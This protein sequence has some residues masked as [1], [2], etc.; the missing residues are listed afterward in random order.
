MPVAARSMAVLSAG[1]MRHVHHAPCMHLVPAAPVAAIQHPVWQHT[2]ICS[3][4][5][6]RLHCSLPG[7]EECYEH[8]ISGTAA[9][10]AAADVPVTNV[11]ACTAQGDFFLFQQL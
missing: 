3:L 11:Y 8:D 7:N 5:C 1:W 9:A 2:C 10:A 6:S 4:S